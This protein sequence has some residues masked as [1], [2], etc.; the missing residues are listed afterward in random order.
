MYDLA[1]KSE[2]VRFVVES[3]LVKLCMVSSFLDFSITD[4]LNPDFITQV[5]N[6]RYR[7]STARLFF[8]LKNLPEIEGVNS[9]QLNTNFSI[10]TS[11]ES[12]E[13][14]S[15]GVKYGKISDTPFVD[16]NIPSI[17]NENFA[18]NNQHI[19]AASVQYAPYHLRNQIWD[20]QAKS[21]LK[22][23]TIK[24]IENIIPNFSNLIESS[25]VLSPQDIENEFGLKEGNLNHGEMTL[26]QFMFMRPTISSSQYA[27]PI[28]NLYI[29]GGGT[30]PGGGLHGGNGYNAA[31]TILKKW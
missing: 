7:G 14:A 24:V 6:I 18:I 19:L 15:D 2:N 8:I 12:L 13:K 26:D 23:N 31:K 10:C 25:Y 3:N 22:T 21:I 9:D 27:T 17:L 28:K 5:N 20:D 11:L 4:N 1:S 30:H 29:C 16:F